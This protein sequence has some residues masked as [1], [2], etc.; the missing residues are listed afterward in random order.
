MSKLRDQ[1]N[2]KNES[3]HHKADDVHG[4]RAKHLAAFT[5]I[6]WKAQ[7]FIPVT[8]HSQLGK[9][10]RNENTNDIELDQSGDACIEKNHQCRGTHSEGHDAIGVR[11]AITALVKLTRQEGV[12]RKNR[13]QGWEAVESSVCRKD[14]NKA[15]DCGYEDK[16][17]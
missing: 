14:Q 15:R 8:D 10:K 16:E 3:G 1:N 12:T 9:R 6:L 7:A 17:K 5:A 11:Q 4:T 13:G 2:S